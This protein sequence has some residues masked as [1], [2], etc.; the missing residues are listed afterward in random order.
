VRGWVSKR[1]RFTEQVAVNERNASGAVLQE[2]Q[3]TSAGHSSAERVND[4]PIAEAHAVHSG[5]G[6]EISKS[7]PASADEMHA[8]G[9]AAADR[10]PVA[11]SAP[12]A[13]APRVDSLPSLDQLSFGSRVS[14]HACSQIS[15]HVAARARY[16]PLLPLASARLLLAMPRNSPTRF[17]HNLDLSSL[18]FLH[19]QGSQGPSI[20]DPDVCLLPGVP[21]VRVEN[22]PGNARRIF[23]GA[24]SC[25]ESKANV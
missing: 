1:I 20:L 15:H 12:V 23:T 22:A 4:S 6:Q 11:E 5:E 21:V 9:N 14:G 13:M 3:Q 8:D 18:F 7:I 19:A 17:S 2:M 10:V 25:E 24:A 16:H